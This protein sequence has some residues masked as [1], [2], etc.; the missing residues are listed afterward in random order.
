[1]PRLGKG[2]SRPWQFT[3]SGP[4]SGIYKTIDGGDIWLKLS[5]GLPQNRQ[6]GRIGL[7]ICRSNPA[8][9][10]ALLD[11]QEAKTRAAQRSETKEA[12]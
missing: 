5:A 8:V 3:A 11:N 4:E 6:I 12:A 7:A 9:V 1:M 2:K 10:Y